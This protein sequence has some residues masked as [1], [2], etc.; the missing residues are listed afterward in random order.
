MT[1]ESRY[2]IWYHSL[3]TTREKRELAIRNNPKNVRFDDLDALLKDNGFLCKQ[4]GGGSS[5]YTYVHPLL[6]NVLT[7][8]FHKPHLKPA[9]VV[10]AVK[11]V[12]I[13]RILQSE[14]EGDAL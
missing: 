1:I 12:D 6:A 5:H 3:M 4:P 14:R 9:F 8:P 2:Y 7:I 11:A 10:K 13:S